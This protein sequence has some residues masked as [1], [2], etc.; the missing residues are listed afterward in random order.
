MDIM[1]QMDGC[2]TKIIRASLI[3]TD[4]VISIAWN[5]LD[6]FD[7][8]ILIMHMK[9]P[10]LYSPYDHPTSK[11]NSLPDTG[12]WQHIQKKCNEHNIVLIVDD[13]RTGFRI[14]LNGSHKAFNFSPDL[15]CLG[16]AM[17][18]GYP[19]SALVGKNSLKEAAKKV[20]FS[21]TQFFN[22]APMSSANATIKELIKI[23]AIKIMNSNGERLRKDL[24]S[25]AKIMALK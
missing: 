3:R 10:V 20:Y 9:L 23:D 25:I 16:K 24:I 17:A 14:N 21:G 4:D 22:A 5:N 8:A 18:N 15:V 11:D 7:Q 1:V 6:E 13:V 12:Y 2:K 19:I